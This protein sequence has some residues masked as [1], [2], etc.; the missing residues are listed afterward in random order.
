MKQSKLIQR[1]GQN[2]VKNLSA[3]WLPELTLCR[4]IGGTIYSVSG[5]YEGTETLD[6]KLGRILGQA[7]EGEG[8]HP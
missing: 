4:K 1:D 5:T 3:Y 8:R 7:V 6:K 2:R